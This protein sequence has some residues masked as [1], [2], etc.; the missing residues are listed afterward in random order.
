MY[1]KL[2]HNLARMAP[3]EIV[4]D[5]IKLPESGQATANSR[6]NLAGTRL[7]ARSDF[8]TPDDEPPSHRHPGWAG[9]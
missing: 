1:R 9:P 5:F 2:E 4:N 6:C 8:R 3:H 7:W